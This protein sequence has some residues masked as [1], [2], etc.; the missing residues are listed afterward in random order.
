MD[1]SYIAGDQIKWDGHSYADDPIPFTAGRAYLKNECVKVANRYGVVHAATASGAVGTLRCR[2]VYA[3]T[4][5]AAG[6]TWDDGAELEAV[7]DGGTGA[8]TVQA[9][10]TGVTIGKAWGPKLATET[11]VAVQFMPELN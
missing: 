7:T 2:G 10:D 8:F 4:A 3:C 6:D 1:Q 5:E 9:K 11:I